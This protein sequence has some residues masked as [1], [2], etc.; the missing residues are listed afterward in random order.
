M[1][2]W[3]IDLSTTALSVESTT[4]LRTHKPNSFYHVPVSPLF[5]LNC[6]GNLSQ[7]SENKRGVG[8]GYQPLPT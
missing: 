7:V 1:M 5:E 3:A 6:T 8:E 4:C 2:L